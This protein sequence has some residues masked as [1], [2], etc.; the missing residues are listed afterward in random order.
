MKRVFSTEG[1]ERTEKSSLKSIF[2]SA[3]PGWL[4]TSFGCVG[5]NT[6]KKGQAIR[7]AQSIEREF[8][9]RSVFSVVNAFCGLRCQERQSCS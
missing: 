7:A 3:E 4:K 1:T 5:E 2:L 9:V 8:S 6:A